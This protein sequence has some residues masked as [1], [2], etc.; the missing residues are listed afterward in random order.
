MSKIITAGLVALALIA[1]V[2]QAQTGSSCTFDKPIEQAWSDAVAVN[3]A[4]PNNQLGG[5]TQ[6]DKTAVA[7]LAWGEK[8]I[9]GSGNADGIRPSRSNKLLDDAMGCYAMDIICDMPREGDRFKAYRNVRSAGE[10]ST[11]A[12]IPQYAPEKH[13]R[14][15]ERQLGCSAGMEPLSFD[16]RPSAPHMSPA[17][18][19]P[20]IVAENDKFAVGADN[21]Y[22][23]GTIVDRT[24]NADGTGTVTIRRPAGPAETELHPTLKCQ[25]KRDVAACRSVYLDYK[26]R[27]ENAKTD[28]L[29]EVNGTLAEYWAKLGCDAGGTDMCSAG[30]SKAPQIV[31]S[32]PRTAPAANRL[33]KGLLSLTGRPPVS[34]EVG[35]DA[36]QLPQAKYEAYMTCW[37]TFYGGYSLQLHFLPDLSESLRNQL[38]EALAAGQEIRESLQ[39]IAHDLPIMASH[40]NEQAGQDA[41]RAARR[42]FDNAKSSPLQTQINLFNERGTVSPECVALSEELVGLQSIYYSAQN[43]LEE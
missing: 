40:L 31:E 6:R 1:P 27:Y 34:T 22:G 16:A 28:E 12:G 43:S 19:P 7:I 14:W 29:R 26:A 38:T 21:P 37:G 20:Q 35:F 36:T 4:D 24:R 5:K 9:L 39:N 32:A 33:Q 10:W 13:V 18:S 30:P 41:Y 25:Q 2:G 8:G 11:G 3:A 17:P 42:P 15:A 23:E